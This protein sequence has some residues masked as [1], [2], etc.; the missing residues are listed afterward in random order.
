MSGQCA[1][2]FA[3]SGDR[4]DRWEAAA[5]K[6]QKNLV[7]WLAGVIDAVARQ[8]LDGSLDARAVPVSEFMLSGHQGNA[9]IA[10][11]RASSVH[12][13]LCRLLAVQVA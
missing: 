8:V 4:Y 13:S 3:V 10:V 6:E 2:E 9:D 1:L 5:R 12:P 7:D 11:S